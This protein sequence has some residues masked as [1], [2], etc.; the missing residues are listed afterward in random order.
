MRRA[1]GRRGGRC[2][3]RA[4]PA[5]RAR[6]RAGRDRAAGRPPPCAR[7]APRAQRSWP[8]SRLPWFWARLPLFILKGLRT[9]LAEAAAVNAVDEPRAKV[10]ESELL[11]LSLNSTGARSRP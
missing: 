7:T 11:R 4:P 2:G 8:Q 3:S 9:L 6:R 1:G 10:V 5:R